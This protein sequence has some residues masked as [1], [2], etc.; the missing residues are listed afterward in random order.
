MQNKDFVQ[1]FLTS[2]MPALEAPTPREL[3]EQV[4]AVCERFQERGRGDILVAIIPLAF[5]TQFTVDFVE[6]Y[7]DEED[8]SRWFE[9]LKRALRERLQEFARSHTISLEDLNS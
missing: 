8:E 9:Q 5:W 6:S 2:L 3:A 1:D 7:M 4:Q